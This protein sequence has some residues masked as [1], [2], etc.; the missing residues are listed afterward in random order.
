MDALVIGSVQ[1]RYRI[2]QMARAVELAG[3]NLSDVYNVDILAAMKM[4]KKFGVIYR[5]RPSIIAGL[6]Q[7]YF[8]S[9]QRHRRVDILATRILMF[10]T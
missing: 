3:E 10:Y 1:E 6:T 9:G 2:A 7:D 5:W 4:L 8:H